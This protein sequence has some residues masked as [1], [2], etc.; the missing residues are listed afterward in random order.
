MIGPL[1]FEQFATVLGNIDAVLSAELRN[2]TMY[3]EFALDEGRTQLFLVRDDPE[4]KLYIIL[5]PFARKDAI[6]AEAAWQLTAHFT[7]GARLFA[8]M[9]CF[10]RTIPYGSD[11][12]TVAEAVGYLTS[13]AD[14]V[15]KS[16]GLGDDV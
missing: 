13:L 1:N 3:G 6:S 4:E 12:K 5:S 2:D 9:Y 10:I 16:L 7:W 11:G 8:D 15:E 14:S